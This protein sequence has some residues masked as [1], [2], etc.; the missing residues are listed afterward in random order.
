MT[1]SMKADIKERWA[2]ELESGKYEQGA[3]N[4][5]ER[6]FDVPG[7]IPQ[8][9]DKF[10]CLGVLCKMALDEGAVDIGNEAEQGSVVQYD[11]ETAYLPRRVIEWAGIVHEGPRFIEG[12]T[13]EESRGIFAVGT[14]GLAEMNDQGTS[15]DSIAETIRERIVGI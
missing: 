10:C 11:D 13:A 8:Q 14:R 3:G 5:H 7:T 9:P 12:G 15:F 2:R 6:G 1:L 4:L